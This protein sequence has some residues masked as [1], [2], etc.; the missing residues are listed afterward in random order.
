MAKFNHAL[1]L[2]TLIVS[3]QTMA[4]DVELVEQQQLKKDRVLYKHHL[5]QGF[6]LFQAVK[7]DLNQDGRDDVVLIVKGTDP[8]QWMNNQFQERVDRNRR[9]IIVLLNHQG[10]YQPFTQNLNA[11]S[12]ENEDGGVY[13][14]PELWIEI[15]NNKLKINYAHGRYGGWGYTFRIEAQD[16]RLIG[17]DSA[18]HFGP[19]V[20]RENSINFLTQKRLER[21]N[22]HEDAEREPI[23][24]E[25]WTKVNT[26]PIYLSK[27][28]DFDELDVY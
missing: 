2:M 8:K 5:P 1:L 13:F 3:M 23:F 21:I 15:K 18:S 26:T 17:Y 14:P 22:T 10:Q 24:K 11:F 20:Q 16:M 7:G 6:S 27:I 28:K 4:A 12:S 25:V 9:G 19:L